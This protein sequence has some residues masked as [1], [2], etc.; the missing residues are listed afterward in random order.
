MV[1]EHST[2]HSQ[3]TVVVRHVKPEDT[4]EQIDKYLADALD[5][6]DHEL[7]RQI[8]DRRVDRV[9]CPACSNGRVLDNHDIFPPICSACEGTG[10]LTKD[11][12]IALSWGARS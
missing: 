5:G 12:V 2:T 7:T 9:Q 11:R 8:A 6:A 1:F 3:V 10:W 4:L